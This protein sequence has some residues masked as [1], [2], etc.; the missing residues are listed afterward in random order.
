MLNHAT[1]SAMRVC[2]KF[3]EG[4]G[5]FRRGL[6]VL[7]VLAGI[8]LGDQAR[9]GT[10]VL[11]PDFVTIDIDFNGTPE[12]IGGGSVTPSY[13]NGELLPYLYCAQ[14]NVSILPG[15]TYS[16]AVTFDGK[17]FGSTVPN[18]GEVAYLLNTYAPSAT[19]SD[20]EGGLQAAIWKEIF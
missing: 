2:G 16:T 7:G 19:T 13:L 17:F 15:H 4:P 20:Q 11:G 10:L 12:M 5:L 18:A 8:A 14:V 1:R 6:A 3:A 9:A